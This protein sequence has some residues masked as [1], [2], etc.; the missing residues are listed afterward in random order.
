MIDP[1]LLQKLT[2][3]HPPAELIAQIA[4]LEPGG[5]L[6]AVLPLLAARLLG[7]TPADEDDEGLDEELATA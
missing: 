1:I 7:A 2:Q 6:P 4:R 3:A 5:T